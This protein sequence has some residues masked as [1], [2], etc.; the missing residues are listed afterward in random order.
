MACDPTKE[1]GK[2]LWKALPPG[3]HGRIVPALAADDRVRNRVQDVAASP[4]NA[5]KRSALIEAVVRLTGNCLGQAI[6][7]QKLQ[8]ENDQ[9]SVF[10]IMK[11]GAAARIEKAIGELSDQQIGLAPGDAKGPISTISRMTGRC[12]GEEILDSMSLPAA[13]KLL[14]GFL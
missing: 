13:L 5:Q 14:V 11:A 7:H 3:T 6:T 9:V 1:T 4:G 8:P 12:A 2:A 10:R